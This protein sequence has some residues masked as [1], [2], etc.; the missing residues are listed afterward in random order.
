MT[1][2]FSEDNLSEEN[3]ILLTEEELRQLE[4]DLSHESYDFAV[5]TIKDRHRAIVLSAAA[6]L[7][8]IL[9]KILKKL[10]EPPLRRGDNLFD[11]ECPLSSFSAKISLAYWLGVL[12][13]YFELALQMV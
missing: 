2:N 13:Y 7:D 3:D 9:E 12:D 6:R 10:M 4:E 5:N 11:V 1:N 8:L